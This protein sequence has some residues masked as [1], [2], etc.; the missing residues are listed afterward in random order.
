MGWFGRWVYV[1]GF[2]DE[3]GVG[4]G[5]VAGF[6]FNFFFLLVD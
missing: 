3:E 1:M 4:W 5:Q 6:A 2:G